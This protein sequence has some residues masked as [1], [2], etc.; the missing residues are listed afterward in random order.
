[1]FFFSTDLSSRMQSVGITEMTVETRDGTETET[2]IEDET[3]ETGGTTAMSG[4]IDGS[5]LRG[6]RQNGRG[7]ESLRRAVSEGR[8][9]DGIRLGRRRND[10]H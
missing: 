9:Q 10:P 8:R 6:G 1:M 3:T 4:E 5:L 7:K 2:S